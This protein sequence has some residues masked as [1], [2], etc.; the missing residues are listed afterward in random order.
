MDSIAT[1]FEKIDRNYPDKAI[2]SKAGDIIKDGGLVAFPTETVYGLGANGLNSNAV[3]KIYAAKG[4]PSDNPLILHIS[5]KYD[6]FPLVKNVTPLA[7]KLIS[8][9]WP[10]PLT[11]IFE[12]SS[13]VPSCIT[14]GMDTV[15]IRFPTDK[16]ALAVIKQSGVPIAAP[17]ANLSGK[18]SP[19]KAIHVKADLYGKIDMILDGGDTEFGVESTVVDVRGEIPIILRPG[20]ITKEMILD[21]TGDVK[22][23]EAVLK[24]PNNDLKPMAPGMKYKHY[25]PKAKIIIVKGNPENV[26]TQISKLSREYIAMGKRVGIMTTEQNRHMYSQNANI[27]VVGDGEN[28]NTVA[29]NLF[30]I[31]REFD[32]MHMDIVYS[33]SFSD[34]GI[35]A[36]IMNRLEKAAGYNIVEV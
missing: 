25:S 31:F 16:I 14:A 19:T 26:A 24:K 11:L 17:S 27:F 29:S 36:A 15:A 4:R 3:N 8:T 13:I 6:I 20:A 35:G 18:P 9:F 23:D 34:D 30:K 10:G 12:K 5:S 28:M 22:I 32:S 33:E 2:I 21:L 7:E 1:I